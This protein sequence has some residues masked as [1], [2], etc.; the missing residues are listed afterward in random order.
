MLPLSMPV[1]NSAT[2]FPSISRAGSAKFDFG[3]EHTSK[4]ITIY[5]AQR[6]TEIPEQRPGQ[7][8][9]TTT[10]STFELAKLVRKN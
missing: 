6:Y 5:E 10:E 2:A 7:E 3:A 4:H 9:H 1:S 8:R